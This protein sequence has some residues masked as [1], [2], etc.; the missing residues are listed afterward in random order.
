M[1]WQ[2][3]VPIED[4]VDGTAYYLAKPFGVMNGTVIQWIYWSL[5]KNGKKGWSTKPGIAISVVCNDKLRQHLAQNSDL[6]A[7]EIPKD[8]DKKW[9]RRE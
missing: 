7:I 9:K 4:L 8:S 1:S 3:I 5:P 2:K 6:H